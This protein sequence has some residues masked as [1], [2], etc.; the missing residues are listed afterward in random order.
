MD[1]TSES[2]AAAAVI[3][4]RKA[5]IE[6]VVPALTR[7]FAILDLVAK[8][9]GLDFTT[10]HGRLGLPKSSTHNLLGTL[11]QLGLL[12]MRPDRGFVLGLKLTELGAL[13]ANHRFVEAESLPLLRAL[14]SELQLTCHLGVS[15]GAEA[16]YLSKIEC[17][18]PIKV[19]SWVGKRFSVHSSALGKVLLAWLPE[20]ELQ[21]VLADI[22]WVQNTRHTITSPTEMRAHLNLVRTR[23]WATD[24]EEN[25]PNI[26][27]VAAP[28]FDRQQNVVAAISAVGTILQVDQS[29]LDLI[30]PRLMA[31]A[32]E[33][34][35]RAFVG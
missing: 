9:P 5:S 35:R 26:R 30:A 25:V 27:C 13:A 2:A 22:S 17:D 23:G 1:G 14:A 7:G 19:D 24:D 33:I 10:I 4:S 21:R 34:S 3:T 11:S 16:V 29:R 32:T 12:R 20:A 31:V 8:N 6:T 15:E 28:V 18:Q